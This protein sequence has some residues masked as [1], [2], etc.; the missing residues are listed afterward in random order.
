[1]KKCYIAFTRV[2]IQGV[3]PQVHAQATTDRTKISYMGTLI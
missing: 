3:P 1:M 2:H